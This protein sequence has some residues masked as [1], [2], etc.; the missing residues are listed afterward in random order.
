MGLYCG[1]LVDNI[2][3]YWYFYFYFGMLRLDIYCLFWDWLYNMYW[4]DMKWYIRVNVDRI[5]LEL[6][7]NYI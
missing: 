2:I 6:I 5:L 4:V 1:L 7:I 3:G